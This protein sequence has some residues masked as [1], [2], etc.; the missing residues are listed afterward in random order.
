MNRKVWIAALLAATAAYTSACGGGGSQSPSSGDGPSTVKDQ[1]K[2]KEPIELLVYAAGVS[3]EEF[4]T[5]F[6]SVLKNKFPHITVN[7]QTNTKGN[8]LA[9]LVSAG[10]IPD[11]IRTDIPTLKS[12][13]LDLQLG[14]DLGELI[15]ANKY[16]MTRFDPSFTQEMV[17]A[18]RTGAI[19]GLPVPPYFPT[20]LY[21]NK[22]LFDKFGVPYPKDGM[23]WDEVYEIAKKM[24][25]TEGGVVYRGFSANF[26]SI[27]RD[28]PF[29]LPV[30]DPSADKLADT[31][32]WKTI[33]NN[34]KRFYDL[35]NNTIE[36]TMNA[37]NNAFGN[38][39]IA[40][41]ANQHN[42]YL[43]IPPEIDWDIVSQPT[44]AGAPKRTGQRG[45]AYWSIT[46][47][48]KHKEEAFR[49]IMEMLSDEVQLEDSKK[50]IPTTLVKKEVRD[51][52]GKGHPVY[53]SKNMKAIS[54][55]EPSAPTPK[56]K[57][58][59]VDINGSSQTSVLY[60]QFIPFAQ[61]K[62]DVNTAL[63]DVEESL[64]KL[65]EQEK[66]K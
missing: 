24:S 6:R 51:A 27:L 32:K 29:S 65:L 3:A 46:R 59:L 22:S 58:E 47:Q 13:Y 16:D 30:L 15:K 12:S 37:E 20:V 66:S 1:D 64:K 43:V 8:S 44:M 63:R 45:P 41:Q 55:Y 9:E 14:Y 4:D 2:P 52:L 56:R 19:Y 31:E 49:V 5:R 7:Y 10:T 57:P 17:D 35:P 60:Q 28:N 23:T 11:L 21:Y 25:R 33:F 36:T 54:Y 61:G 62:K 26:N 34:Y 48:S 18:G 53:G 50:G 38:G 40:M 39:R 42:I